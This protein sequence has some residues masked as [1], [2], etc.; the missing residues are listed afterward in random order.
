MVSTAELD[1]FLR[2][3]TQ[4]RSRLAELGESD[5]SPSM[6]E[7]FAEALDMSQ[8]LVLAD[9]ELRAQQEQLEVS[10]GELARLAARHDRIV[11]ASDRAYIVTTDMGVLRDVNPAGRA[12]LSLPDFVRSPRPIA[13]RFSELDRA[14]VRSLINRA[15][16][17]PEL[18]HRLDKVVLIDRPARPVAVAVTGFHDPTTGELLLDWEITVAS[19]PAFAPA[20]PALPTQDR[21]RHA[22][23]PAEAARPQPADARMVE[24]VRDLSA[25]EE[26]ADALARV[27]DEVRTLIDGCEHVG[28]VLPERGAG[29]SQLA[30]QEP[31]LRALHELEARHKQGPVQDAERTRHAVLVSSLAHD[32]R[33]PALARDATD[34]P[35]SSLVVIPVAF[36][37]RQAG[38]LTVAT[39]AAQGF[40]ERTV[41]QL[42][43]LTGLVMPVLGLVRQRQNLRTALA[44]RQEIGTAVGILVE[45][46]RITADAAFTLMVAASQRLNVK[47]RTIAAE[48]MH[49][50]SDPDDLT[51]APSGTRRSAH[52]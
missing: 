38:S 9:A 49:T 32:L 17:E 48:V 1:G 28:L 43:C 47:L 42:N 5:A 51:I 39:H 23:A 29:T 7:L 6:R 8:E 12:L 15:A 21:W 3:L 36:A 34:L 41:A 22:E 20:T 31:P 46:H 13:T 26:P 11:N 19:R 52:P 45:R 14:A 37:G 50:G 27:V 10:R 4:R 33:W 25:L 18:T 35:I 40:D 24:L 44:S 2:T 30:H 16:R